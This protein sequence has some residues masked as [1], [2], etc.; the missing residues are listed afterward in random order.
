[1]YIS[2]IAHDF[3]L[4]SSGNFSAHIFA[5]NCTSSDHHRI[6]ALCKSDLNGTVHEK[7]IVIIRHIC[8]SAYCLTGSM[9]V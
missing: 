7:Y 3:D 5:Y 2:K 1:M 4:L 8:D 6:S 9:L